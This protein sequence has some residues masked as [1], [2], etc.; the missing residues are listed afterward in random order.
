MGNAIILTMKSSVR[1]GILSRAGFYVKYFLRKTL[2][3]WFEV[4]RPKMR[5]FLYEVMYSAR[6]LLNTHALMPSP[7]GTDIVETMFGRFRIRPHTVDM[8]NVSPAF[9]R[10]DINHL[11]GLLKRLR[12][13]GKRVLFLDIGADLG[14]FAVTAGNSMKGHEE[15]GIMAFEPAPSS[16]ALLEENI[17]LNGLE[18][19]VRAYEIALWSEEAGDLGFRFN[20]LTPGSSG[21]LVEGAESLRV[22][23]G[24]LDNV[25]GDEVGRYDA[26]VFKMDVEGVESEVLKGAK[27]TLEIISEAYL[28]VED[29]INPDVIRYLEKIGAEF[30]LKVTPYNSWWCIN[31]LKAKG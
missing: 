23:A 12:G 8:S 30:L 20:P 26:L 6:K 21:L 18:D 1:Y 31:R 13:E 29:F 15:F 22:R 27:K 25:L 2:F 11:L 3:I 10:D 7:F 17:R 16:F 14:T 4:R 28:L 9:E 5:M 24:T 19:V